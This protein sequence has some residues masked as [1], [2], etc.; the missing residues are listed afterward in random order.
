MSENATDHYQN[1]ENNALRNIH[2]TRFEKG[3]A[4]APALVKAITRGMIDFDQLTR[5]LSI[6]TNAIPF[7]C[8]I[9]K[10]N[11]EDSLISAFNLANF[12]RI[13]WD[14]GLRYLHRE[15]DFDPDDKSSLAKVTVNWRKTSLLKK[16]GAGGAMSHWTKSDDFTMCHALNTEFKG[17]I[18][19]NLTDPQTK[20]FLPNRTALSWK[21]R[22]LA[23]F[24]GCSSIKNIL[25]LE[26]FQQILQEGM[27]KNAATTNKL[28]ETVVMDKTE[29]TAMNATDV[30]AVKGN[31]VQDDTK[32]PAGAKKRKPKKKNIK[33][34]S[35]KNAAS[36][37]ENDELGLTFNFAEAEWNMADEASDEDSEPVAKK[38]RSKKGDEQQKK[39]KKHPMLA[40][41]DEAF[42]PD[43]DD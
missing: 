16:A 12:Q 3:T 36:G 14:G 41:V 20:E 25:K 10:Y 19:K 11:G 8:G 26:K 4:F 1:V 2:D 39:K 27:K 5:Q 43:E 37:K 35:R 23:L 30:D 32:A 33:K 29:E 9:L 24:D 34:G 38:M 21:K 40:K 22:C 42:D 13:P 18:L 6:P 17:S 31:K 28:E 15:D 7:L